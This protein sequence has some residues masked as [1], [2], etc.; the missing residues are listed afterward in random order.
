MPEAPREKLDNDLASMKER[1][2]KLEPSEQ[3]EFI[4]ALNEVA[5]KAVPKAR[6]AKETFK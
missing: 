2:L 5:N 6:T 4:G 3:V 1:I